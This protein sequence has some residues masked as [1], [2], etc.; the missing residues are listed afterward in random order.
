MSEL[1]VLE[2]ILAYNFHEFFL[3]D[4]AAGHNVLTLF[5]YRETSS[6]ETNNVPIS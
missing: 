4:L 1:L 5:T 6:K 3:I 2:I